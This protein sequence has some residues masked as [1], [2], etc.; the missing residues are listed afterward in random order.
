MTDGEKVRFSFLRRWVIE[1]WG[2]LCILVGFVSRM[3]HRKALDYGSGIPLLGE[4]FLMPG[5]R[6]LF[7]ATY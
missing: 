6:P 2:S 1:L 4:I 3:L 7:S 5:L